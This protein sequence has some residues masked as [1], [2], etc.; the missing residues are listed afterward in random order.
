MHRSHVAGLGLAVAAVLVTAGAVTGLSTRRVE[1]NLGPGD[2][3]Y[4]TGFQ[5]NSDVE[6]KVGWHWTTYH[7]AV[8]LPF[9]TDSAELVLTLRY[10]RV[11]GEEAVVN[12]SVAGVKAEAFSARGGEVRTRALTFKE[13]RGPLD[14]A[15]ESDSHERRDM[16][17]KLDR[18]SLEVPSGDSIRLR[19]GAALRPVLAVILLLGGLLLLGAHPVVAGALTLLAAGAFA[20]RASVDLFGAFREARLAPVMLVVST[21]V[22]WAVKVR[23][24]RT[25]LV[26]RS[27]A[28]GLASAA[29]F[30]MLLRLALVSHPDF[31]YPDLLTHTRV[32]EAIRAEGPRFFLHP[33]DALNS[34]GAWTKPVMGSVSSLPYAVMFHAPFAILAAALDLSVDQIETAMKAGASLISVLPIMLAGVL[35]ARLQG[36]PLA[37]LALCVIPTYTSRLSFALMPALLGHVFDLMALL[38]IASLWNAEPALRGRAAGVAML[39]LFAGHLSYT[40]SVVNEGLFVVVL[41]TLCL[42][43]D[44]ARR[45]LGGLLV[46]AECGAAILAFLLYYRHFVGDVFGLLARITGINSGRGAASGTAASV[47]PIESFWDLLFERSNTFFGMSWTALAVVGVLVLGR[48]IGPA[49]RTLAPAWFLTYLA[50]IL[51]RAKIPDVFRYGHETLFLTPLVSLLSGSAL[52][53]AGRRGGLWRV[54]AALTFAVLVVVS[55][56]EQWLAMALQFG[57]AR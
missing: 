22:L 12:V 14:I 50:L 15:I 20:F 28:G 34:Q 30:T 43:I 32:A 41:V 26:E 4:V 48:R 53:E 33:A 3:P 46:L 8:T 45:G 10:A 17:L 21:L 7:A 56:R 35:A 25:G 29:L 18:L 38:A 52:V 54:A 51:L 31:Y 57:N 16:G 19:P 5:R 49:F 55:F 42:T 36:P 44:S 27:V 23:M 2:T 47:Y 24:Q 9:E 37:A 13:V 6:D 40:S 1:L 39:S 11:F